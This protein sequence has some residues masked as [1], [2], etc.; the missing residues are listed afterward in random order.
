[1][2][3]MSQAGFLRGFSVEKIEELRRKMNEQ[4][5]EDCDFWT[6][7]T[8]V[9]YKDEKVS[10]QALINIKDQ[11]IKGFV[12][13]AQP[14]ALNNMSLK[15]AFKNPLV[16]KAA[17]ERGV[18]GTKMD[19]ALEQISEASSQAVKQVA[20]SNIKYTEGKFHEFPAIYVI[21]PKQF[22]PQPRKKS[23]GDGGGGFDTRVKLPANAFKKENFPIGGKVLQ[24]IR[25]GKYLISGGLLT[26]LN[27]MSTKNTY[28]QSLT[29]FKTTTKTTHEGDMTFI[30]HFIVP[31]D[32]NF[33]T[34]GY[35]NREEDEEMLLKLIEILKNGND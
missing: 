25:V 17:K 34:E 13:V 22:K 23:K 35:F 31:V 1:M 33:G 11:F 2:I 24:A 21:P 18:S 12:N 30:D 16:R 32:S 20:E 29:K 9:D 10:E 4:M 15:D 19:E 8:I 5:S 6:D 14:G 3:A 28:C 7:I 26:S 27:Y